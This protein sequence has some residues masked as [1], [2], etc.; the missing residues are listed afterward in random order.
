MKT[1][2][3]IFLLSSVLLENLSVTEKSVDQEQLR[4]YEELFIMR[5]QYFGGIDLY[6]HQDIRHR[7]TK[8]AIDHYKNDTLNQ[9]VNNKYILPSITKLNQRDF[10][11]EKIKVH[12]AKIIEQISDSS[13]YYIPKIWIGKPV[14]N[15][16]I[17]QAILMEAWSYGEFAG[18]GR[19]F[20]F[21]KRNNK[22]KISET[23]VKWL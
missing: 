17:D 14:F 20:I 12:S 4:I 9:R 22:W 10:N 23:I 6:I 1:I 19:I 16:T 11:V 2:L 15:K 18:E 5:V 3:F 8:M 13:Y 21:K 7:Y